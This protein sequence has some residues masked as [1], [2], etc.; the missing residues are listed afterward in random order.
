MGKRVLI[1]DDDDIIRM[2]SEEILHEL[3]YTALSAESGESGL[4]LFNEQ[5][6][7]IDLIILDLTMPG[8][9]VVTIFEDMLKSDPDVRV[10]ISSGNSYDPKIQQLLSLGARSFLQ[11][12]YTIAD[13][14]NKIKEN[15]K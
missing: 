7:E 9:S 8:R 10:L 5:F 6:K 14:E 3:G 13:M 4:T 11:K 2:T 1:I 12:P 15:A